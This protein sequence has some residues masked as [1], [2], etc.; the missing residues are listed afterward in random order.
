MTDGARLRLA[1]FAVFWL[2]L[3]ACGGGD[4]DGAASRAAE[5]VGR[6]SAGATEREQPLPAGPSGID[7]RGLPTLVFVDADG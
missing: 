5:V 2:L 4:G 7:T 3:A 1:A 6:G